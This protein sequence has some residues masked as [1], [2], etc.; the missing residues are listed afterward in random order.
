[1]KKAIRGIGQ[2]FTEA[3]IFML[4]LC[5]ASAIYG[6]ILISST[7]I[8]PT[9][10]T[11]NAIYVQIGAIVIGLALFVIFSYV[12]IDII[13][14]KSI[15][16][17]AFS[18]L[19]ILTLVFWGEGEIVGRRAWLRFW[20]IGIQPAEIVKVTFI[21]IVAKMMMN[22][23]ERKTLNSFLSIMQ[24]GIIF[25][26]MFLLVW[27][28]SEDIGTAL[29]YLAIFVIM[30]F[31]G[32]VRMRW[33]IIGGVVIGLI[34]PI[35]ANYVL[36]PHQIDRIRAPFVSAYEIDPT[37]RYVTWQVSQG[38]AAI[39]GG[40]IFGQGLGNGSLTQSGWVPVQHTDF[41]F[42][43]AAEELGFVGAFFVILLLSAIIVR[44]IYVG[45]KSNNPLGLIVCAGVAAMFI[46]QTIM[47]LGMVLD[48]MP[49]IGVTLP[50][51]S[52]GGSSIVT[53]FAAAGIVSGIKMRPKQ[54]RFRGM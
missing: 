6:V 34:A 50:F 13:A 40:G 22:F 14:D 48:V 53:C 44:C 8:S 25:V 19:F 27:R 28:V 37:G 42:T 38:L 52:Y 5:L 20:G 9:M 1:M 23:K 7:V 24:L 4:A 45:V 46:T 12:D 39:S 54:A 15:L 41:I 32:G 11:A 43:V 17:F 29:V 3:D 30:L 2:F 10:R 18:V 16:L 49:V 33:F 36:E 35:F 47:N 31:L 51:F 21:I 26:I